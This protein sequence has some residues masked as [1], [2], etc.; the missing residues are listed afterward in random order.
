M[1]TNLVT[2][3][4]RSKVSILR[5][6]IRLMINSYKQNIY[7]RNALS[8]NDTCKW[9]SLV[10]IFAEQFFSNSGKYHTTYTDNDMVVI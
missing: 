10:K 5:K 8:L 1:L 4:K 9:L 2:F 7:S 3:K 6:K